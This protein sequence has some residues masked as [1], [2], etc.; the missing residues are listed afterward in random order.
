MT[1][2]QSIGYIEWI[3]STDVGHAPEQ[4]HAY[5]TFFRSASRTLID[6]WKF[7]RV[8]SQA[9]LEDDDFLVLQLIWVLV[10]MVIKVSLL[11]WLV[12]RIWRTECKLLEGIR[13]HTVIVDFVAGISVDLCCP[14]GHLIPVATFSNLTFT[15]VACQ[16]R[17]GG[18]V[19]RAHYWH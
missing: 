12:R 15:N 8:V 11:D 7:L 14:L 18:V 6:R 19:C 1:T 3:E 17:H 9:D 13:G 16:S 4:I 10:S 5:C 2:L